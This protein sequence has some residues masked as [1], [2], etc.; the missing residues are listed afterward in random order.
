[1]LKDI[2]LRIVQFLFKKN[3]ETNQKEV[4]DNNKYAT[5]YSQINEIN[6][7]A[8]FANKLSNYIVSDSTMEIDGENARTD[9]LNKVGQSVW[10]KLKKITATTLGEG[11]I[12]IVPY[13]A[14]GKLYYNLIPQNRLTIDKVDGELIT[15]ATVLAERKIITGTISSKVYLRWTNYDVSDSGILTINQQYSDEDGNKIAK[16]EFWNNIVDEMSISG[17]DRVPFGYIKSPIN[18]RKTDDKYGVPITYGCDSTI[19]EIRECLAQIQREYKLKETF[20]GADSTMFDGKD[21]L[22]LN[23]LFRK[24]DTSDDTFFEVFDPAFRP[25]TERLQELYKR[26]EHEV[27]VNAGILSEVETSKATATEVKRSLFDTFTLVDDT[28]SNIEKG[29][30]D[31]FYSCNI[32]ANAFNLSAQGEY[33]LKYDWDYSMIED[34]E[35]DFNHM[36]IGVDKGAI[37]IAELRNWI[38]P[39]ETMEESEKKV[40]EIEAKEPSIEQIVGNEVE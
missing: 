34:L 13:V 22:P 20:V 24:I 37:D 14:K 27:G 31:F 39:T 23:G 6:F 10:K 16:P 38:K 4:T 8:I 19:N 40:L 18:N 28:R 29:L 30:E 36:V 33:E 7:S 2:F 11:G 12:I 15:G 1:M 35:S 21:K 5:D 25:Y 9:L 32:L 26:L 17:V 3:T